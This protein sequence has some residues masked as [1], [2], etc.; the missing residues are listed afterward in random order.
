[1]Q[2]EV[3][4]RAEEIRKHIRMQPF[5]PFRLYLS[6]GLSYDVRHPELIYVGRREL[7]IALELGENDV[8]ERSAYCDPVHVTNI[9]PLDG[10]KRKRRRTRGT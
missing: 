2:A 3:R 4:M 1:M 9:E 6:N 5:R 7:V 10:A 8:P